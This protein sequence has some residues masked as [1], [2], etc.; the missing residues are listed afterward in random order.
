MSGR[1][2]LD[3]GDSR[4]DV[5]VDLDPLRHRVEDP[6][7]AVVQRRVTPRQKGADAVRREFTFDGGGP[8]GG[9]R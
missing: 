6:Q 7:C 9:P 8:D 4:D 3:R 1:Q 2:R 5:V